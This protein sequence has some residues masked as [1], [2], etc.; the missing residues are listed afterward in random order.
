[1]NPFFTLLFIALAR[2]TKRGSD[3]SI[4]HPTAFSRLRTLFYFGVIR[5]VSGYFDQKVL[6][7]W[8]SDE[9]DWDKEIVLITGGAGGI[10]G[11]VVKLLSERGTKIVVLDV[12]PMTFEARAY[13]PPISRFQGERV[14][15]EQP[16]MSITT[17]ATS[18]A[19]QP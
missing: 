8:T 19:P 18:P 17:N 10:G 4:L 3:L 13:P 2:Y 12:I 6:D 11:Q 1:M 9:Y 16:R 7:N 14:N 15:R 5:L